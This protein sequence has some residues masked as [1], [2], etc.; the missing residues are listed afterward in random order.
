[1]AVGSTLRTTNFDPTNQVYY[2][3][4]LLDILTPG[5]YLE[6]LAQKSTLPTHM[7]KIV[8]FRRF[9]KLPA[10]PSPLN[11]GVNPDPRDYDVNSVQATVA[12][13]GDRTGVTD[14]VDLTKPDKHLT[15]LVE[16]LGQQASE[17][18]EITLRDAVI[19]AAANQF[20]CDAAG[21]IAGAALVNTAVPVDAR[22]FARTHLF[23]RNNDVPYFTEIIEPGPGFNSFPVAKSYFAY[24]HPDVGLTIRDLA[25]FVD[26]AEYASRMGVLNGE[27]GMVRGAGVRIIESTLSPIVAG[28][29]A[30]GADAYA[31]LVCGPDAFG[32]VNLD[33]MSIQ[34]YYQDFGSGDD[35]LQMVAKV[36]WKGVWTDLILDDDRMAVAWVLAE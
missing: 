23:L 9:E 4:T 22:I 28:G 7:G 34:T 3:D 24:T 33:G 32:T 8:D 20:F 12:P 29:G 19:P 13:Y 21:S 17:T 6:Q 14:M 16:R 27:I 11:E 2:D 18:K 36:G 1:M 15:M 31:I 10:V 30:G 26:V 5:L 25:G 35:T